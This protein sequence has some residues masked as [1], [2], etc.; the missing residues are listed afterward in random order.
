MTKKDITKQTKMAWNRT[1][2]IGGINIAI[3]SKNKNRYK[4][5]RN[6]DHFQDV[7]KNSFKPIK[8]FYYKKDFINYLY[9]Q[10]IENGQIDNW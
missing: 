6:S 2:N 1:K 3:V 7:L 10:I 5:I 8:C 4:I 9:N